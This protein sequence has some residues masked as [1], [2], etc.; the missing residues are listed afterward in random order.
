M[1]QL[2][3]IAQNISLEK[4]DVYSLGESHDFSFLGAAGSGKSTVSR[5]W[6]TEAEKTN[7]AIIATDN[8]RAF[9]M[10]RTE[11]H[12]LRETNKNVFTRTQDVA[13]MVKELVQERLDQCVEVGERP[14]IICDCVT[15]DH[16]MQALLKQGEAIS[17]VAAYAGEPGFLGIAERADARAR[18]TGAAPADKERFV[19]TSSLLE[20]HANASARLLSSIPTAVKTDIYDT[21]VARGE[22]PIK[23]ATIDPEAHTMEI[24]DLRVMSEFLNKRNINKEAVNPVDLILSKETGFLVTHPEMKAKSIIDLVAATKHK[25]AYNIILKDKNDVPYF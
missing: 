1:A 4:K 8:Y 21:N 20:G 16:K 13:Y 5:Q 3:E 11:E 18:D 14:N 10:P 7:Y 15:L 2:P 23:I 12:E 24:S 9:T 22:K 25:P 19:N 17:V 6:L